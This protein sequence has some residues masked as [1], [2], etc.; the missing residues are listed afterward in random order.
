MVLNAGNLDRR[1]QFMRAEF[2]NGPTGMEQ[3]EFEALG[4]PVFAARRDVSDAEKFTAGRIEATLDTRFTVRSSPFT[5]SIVPSDRLTC[6]GLD[7]NIIGIKQIEGRQDF[8]E[9]TC[10]ARVA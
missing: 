1:V 6:E 4:S 8:L 7:F 9:I 2:I 5:R 3:G 10:K